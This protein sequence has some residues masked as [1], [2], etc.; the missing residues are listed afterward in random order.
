MT[1]TTKKLIKTRVEK[2]LA[3]EVDFAG[4]YLDSLL[5]KAA[6][7]LKIEDP[8]SYT[9][10]DY[11]RE[12][13]RRYAVRVQKEWGVS[14]PKFERMQRK[15]REILRG[16]S[17]G[18]SM[19]ERKALSID[20]KTICVVDNC[21]RYAKSCKWQPT[22]GSFTI[23]FSL[24]SFNAIEMIE[25]VWTIRKK[26]NACSWL[27]ESG[28]KGK[29]SVQLVDGFLIGR[30]HARSIRECEALEKRKAQD[31]IGNVRF[32]DRFVGLMDRHIVGACEPGVM[33][34]CVRHGLDHNMGYRI[35]YLLEL[36]DTTALPYLERLARVAKLR[37]TN[38][39][40]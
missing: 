38:E 24:K 8:K 25:G 26:G 14:V 33:A 20:G 27:Q 4:K 29:Y 22:H 15:A 37:H 23:F 34:F 9:A 21:Q 28:S 3:A 32:L 12:V 40:D 18:Y 31:A 39:R 36:G 1:T 5:N 35:G 11:L 16:F 17:T 10:A 30:S 7:Y 13:K 19:G 2:E 6:E